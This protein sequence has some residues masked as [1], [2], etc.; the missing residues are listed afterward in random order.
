MAKNDEAKITPFEWVLGTLM[1]DEGRT[2]AITE[3]VKKNKSDNP[4]HTK[5][6]LEHLENKKEF[7][8]ASKIY[9]R[10]GNNEY[11]IRTL[12]AA[13]E[14]ILFSELGRPLRASYQGKLA[15]LYREKGDMEK[16]RQNYEDALRN[17]EKVGRFDMAAA[18]SAIMGDSDR[19]E[20][21]NF[22]VKHLELES[23]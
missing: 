1:T 16:S 12:E 15:I 21:Y 6:A 5:I 18:T 4:E 17:Y 8:A 7:S 20:R 23:K 19:A 2:A 22:L 11:A 14:E 13:V 10:I 9:E 3:V